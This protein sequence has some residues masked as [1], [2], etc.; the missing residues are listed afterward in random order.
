MIKLFS[1]SIIALLF[2]AISYGQN[3]P[4]WEEDYQFEVLT[5]QADGG[6]VA[7]DITNTGKDIQECIKKA[8]SQALFTI[9]FKGYPAS[10]TASA[11]TALSDMGNYHQNTDFFTNYL[12]SNTAGLAFVNK[13][14]TNTRKPGG[15]VSKKVIRS[16][17]TVTILKSK[18]RENLQEQGYVESAANIAESLGMNPTVMIVPSNAWM[19]TA[20]FHIQVESNMGLVDQY[21]YQSALSDPEMGIFQTI[22]GY[23]KQPLQKNGFEIANLSAQ[24]S[25]IANENARDAMRETYIQE[26]PLDL[27]AKQANAD[28]WLNVS[29]ITETVS[30]GMEKQYQIT[31]NG[32]D[33]LTM[34]DVINGTP[35]VVKSSGD[36]DMTLIRTTINAAIDNLM[37]E[38]IDFFTRRVEEGIPGMMIF[39]VSDD[40]SIDFEDEIEIEGEEYAFAEVIDAMVSKKAKEY[41]PSGSSTSTRRAYDVK[42]PTKIEN[43]LSGKVEPYNYE[44]FARKVK[45]EIKKLGGIKA[46]VET[47]GLGKVY[48]IF[49]EEL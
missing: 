32:V 4:V 48:V 21:D 17:T 36:N 37:P 44:K 41:S 11:S 46:K 20:G 31:L 33:P 12:S 7:I 19:K 23:L 2:S 22:E 24:I 3:T 8:K 49:T 38:I 34:R 16:T 47:V 39:K 9:I 40:V 26:S 25:Q 45:S 14:K 5:D 1:L 35:Q 15:K 27:L 18:L 29:V 43:K 13:A 30:G 6:T 42:I 28:I 10:N